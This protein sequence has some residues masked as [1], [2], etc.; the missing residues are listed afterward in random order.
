MKGQKMRDISEARLNAQTYLFD[1]IGRYSTVIRSSDHE[2]VNHMFD[3]E[4]LGVN[5]TA[6][7]V[8]A[9]YPNTGLIMLSAK[10]DTINARRI[11]EMIFGMDVI[12]YSQLA[13]SPLSRDYGETDDDAIEYI[14][15]ILTAIEFYTEP[16]G[17]RTWTAK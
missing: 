5:Y 15:E 6:D 10:K 12:G 9:V 2:A 16:K 4:N 17:C 1:Q 3:F 8:L 13:A 14:D 11:M 7:V